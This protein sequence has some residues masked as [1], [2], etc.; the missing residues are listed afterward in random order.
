MVQGVM[1]GV[2]TTA[3]R[4]NRAAASGDPESSVAASGTEAV[5]AV[6]SLDAGLTVGSAERQRTRVVSGVQAV[7]AANT[8]TPTTATASPDTGAKMDE[9]RRRETQVIPNTLRRP[10]S[11]FNGAPSSYPGF[12]PAAA[13]A[14]PHL[15]RTCETTLCNP[16][17]N[18]SFADAG[19]VLSL[20]I[21]YRARAEN[22]RGPL[23]AQCT[24]ALLG[25][26]TRSHFRTRSVCRASLGQSS[27]Y[28][29]IPPLA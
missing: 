20:D 16:W 9:R 23:Q 27:V 19:L 1:I 29:P 14:P 26:K 21:D 13:G 8:K 25:P 22:V 18:R 11:T 3:R 2:S 5:S 15:R 17:D 12:S 28:A 10:T 7:I 4:L 6:G 24:K